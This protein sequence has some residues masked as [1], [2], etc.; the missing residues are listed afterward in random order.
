MTFATSIVRSV[1]IPASLF[2]ASLF[3]TAS[4]AA[5][6]TAEAR[7]AC[8]GDAFHFCSD[9]IPDIRKIEACLADKLSQLTPACQAEFK[10]DEDKKTLL[11]PPEH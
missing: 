9:D 8:E 7:S 6:V 10:P 3:A 2:L 4:V 11:E 5:E 1:A